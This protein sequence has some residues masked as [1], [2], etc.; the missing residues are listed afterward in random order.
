MPREATSQLPPHLGGI[1]SFFIISGCCKKA[2]TQPQPQGVVQSTP[3]RGSRRGGA[4][5]KWFALLALFL[6]GA[7][8]RMISSRFSCLRVHKSVVMIYNNS[9]FVHC[10]YNESF[11]PE[12]LR[13]WQ[14]IIPLLSQIVISREIY[15]DI[16]YILAMSTRC[17][18]ECKRSN[19]LRRLGRD[20]RLAVN[21]SISTT[22][23]IILS[24]TIMPIAAVC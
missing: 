14:V 2:G 4:D 21:V 18:R 3:L 17:K 16:A 15:T 24:S 9:F 23:H 12:C 8:L 22:T 11:E 13:N 5:V 19:R 7:L 10:R 1:G 20:A 6:I